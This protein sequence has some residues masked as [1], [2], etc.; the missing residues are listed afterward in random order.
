[1]PQLVTADPRVTVQ[2]MPA[3]EAH[4]DGEANFYHL[5]ADGHWVAAIQLNGEFT[6][7]MQEAIMQ[8]LAD[9][10]REPR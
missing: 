6:T 1:M 4:A 9:A 2:P 8:K 3:I 10:L 7:P 5:I